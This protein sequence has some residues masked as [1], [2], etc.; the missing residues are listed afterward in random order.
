MTAAQGGYEGR[1][2]LSQL[3]PAEFATLFERASELEPGL[4]T[5]PLTANFHQNHLGYDLFYCAEVEPPQALTFEEAL[6]RIGGQL[7]EE[8]R[9]ERYA[10]LRTEVQA[11][12]PLIADASAVERLARSLTKISQS[13]PSDAELIKVL[14][15]PSRL[16]LLDL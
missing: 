1:V 9:S 14:L 4:V 11:A 2:R 5:P 13:S 15:P 3:E 6:P 8:R 12:H 7:A 16:R 10:A